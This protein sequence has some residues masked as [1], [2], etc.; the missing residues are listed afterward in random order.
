VTKKVQF[1]LDQNDDGF[2]PIRVELLNATALPSGLFRLE[3]APYFIEGVS[4]RD[5]VEA[6]PTDH[7]DQVRF[8]RVVEQSG[9]AALSIITLDASVDEQLMDLAATPQAYASFKAQLLNMEK[10]DLIIVAELAL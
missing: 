1:I 10:L 7:P 4:Y 6:V 8:V 2:P 9:F 3:N 5:L